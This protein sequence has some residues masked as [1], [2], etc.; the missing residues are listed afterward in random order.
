MGLID[1][2][3]GF[4]VNRDIDKLQ[5]S[6]EWKHLMHKMNDSRLKM[7]EFKI[8]HIERKKIL[9]KSISKNEDIEKKVKMTKNNKHYQT[10][11]Y[12]K[13]RTKEIKNQLGF[14]FMSD[15]DFSTYL[16]LNIEEEEDFLIKKFTPNQ[17]IQIKDPYILYSNKNISSIIRKEKINSNGFKGEKCMYCNS[18]ISTYSS[19]QFCSVKCEKEYTEFKRK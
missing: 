19:N 16:K 15:E 9:L 1:S 6:E 3:L 13:F 8:E 12:I 11:G 17:L 5:N 14:D 7:D 4:F 10:K 2:I 18:I